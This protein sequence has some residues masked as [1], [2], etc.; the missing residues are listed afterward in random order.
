MTAPDLFVV[1]QK[2]NQVKVERDSEV[3]RNSFG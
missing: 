2:E 1:L 3:D